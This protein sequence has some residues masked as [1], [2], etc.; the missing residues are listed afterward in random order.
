[1][2]VAVA[3][4]GLAGLASA[5]FLAR[6]GHD[7]TL[8]ERDAD[9]PSA[10]AWRS[11]RRPGVPQLRQFHGF[12]A[13]TRNTLL[14]RAPDVYAALLSGGASEVDVL[15][16]VPGAAAWPGDPPLVTV[17]CRRTTLESA[18]RAAVQA[19]RK[20][21][22]TPGAVRGVVRAQ[23]R[24]VGL[25]VDSER[26]EADVV[27]DATGRRA[28][29]AEWLVGEVERHAAGLVYFTRWYRRIAGDALPS[30]ARLDVGTYR[31]VLMRADADF[32]SLAFMVAASEH[33]L[34][35]RL[36]SPEAHHALGM[37]IPAIARWIEPAVARPDT[38][39]LYMGG[40]ENTR[41]WPDVEGLV[42]VGDAA[43]CTNP[44]FGRGTGFAF[45][46]ASMLSDDPTTYRH[47]ATQ[48]F[49]PWFEDSVAR[50][51]ARTAMVVQAPLTEEQRLLN[52]LPARAT[53]TTAGIVAWMRYTQSI[54]HPADLRATVHPT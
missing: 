31:A 25:T 15:A 1:M 19:E 2:R 44:F 51:D 35:Q 41:W 12:T 21:T 18:L 3:G 54:G 36:R 14:E 4:A 32:M 33:T 50:D 13:P 38:D 53:T 43:I 5:L 11:W 40:L 20:V 16:Q 9:E 30:V 7:V 23:D 29:S 8:V 47:R 10:D 46:Q 28:R 37:S 34:R 39:V 26:L 6:A 49:D 22:W 45:V 24:V 42:T 48:R 52:D 17:L 27:V